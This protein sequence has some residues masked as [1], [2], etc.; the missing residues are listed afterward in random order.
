[1]P[2]LCIIYNP[3]AGK[4]RALRRLE[5]VR[6][7]WGD[8]AAFWPTERPGDATPLARRAVES[9]FETIVAAGGDGTVHDVAAGILLAGRP[10]VHFAVIPIGS[11]NDFVHGLKQLPDTVVRVD[12]GRARRD[13]GHSKHFVCNLGM[14][15]N[16]AVTAEARR[17]RWL[18]G[19]ALYGWAAVR[20]LRRQFQTPMCDLRID[21][22]PVWRTPTLMLAVL[23]AQREGGFVMAP[24]AKLDDGLF[25]FVHAGALSRWNVITLLPRLAL[26]GPP[27]DRPDIR[28]GTCRSITVESETP[29]NVHCDGEFLCEAADGMRSF[30]IDL[31]PAALAVDVGLSKRGGMPK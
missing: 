13:D 17:I 11:A 21:D 5:P 12:V 27:G 30:A 15:F 6:L 14:G 29:L 28:R 18:Q 25:N 20:V 9:G 16:G 1:M 26:F 2:E 24:E 7:A 4:G 23:L 19:A 8:R 31:L 3:T 22:G 10:D